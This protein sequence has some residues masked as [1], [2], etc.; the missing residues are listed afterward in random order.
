MF[1]KG[2]NTMSYDWKKM[3]SNYSDQKEIVEDIEF[4]DI[5]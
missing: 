2:E 3:L 5:L 4:E 1:S